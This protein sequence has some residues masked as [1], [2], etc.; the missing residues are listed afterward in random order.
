M[1]Y[2]LDAADDYLFDKAYSALLPASRFV[3]SLLQSANHTVASVPTSP[4]VSQLLSY[5]P[6]PPLTSST[7]AELASASIWPRDYILRQTLSLS[8]MTM[9]GIHL[10]YLTVAAASYYFIFNREMENHPRFLDGQVGKEIRCSLKAFPALTAMT[11]PWFVGEVRGHGRYYDRIDDYGWGYALASIPMFLLFTDYCI[12]WVHRLEHHPSIYKHLHKLHHKWIIPTPFAS[13]A[14]HPV[15]GYLQ[16]LPYHIFPMIFPLH[17]KLYLI[18]F[19]FVNLWSILIHDSD[20]ITGHPLE[21]II[22]GPAH[23]TLH[24]LYFTVNYGQYFTWADR[25]H[26]SYRQPD[27]SLD[28]MLQVKMQ[29][30]KESKKSQ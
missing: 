8:I 16:S 4:W 15:D 9:V 17:K 18:L 30:K 1:E 14:F 2:I 22:N 10:M 26:L 25:T 13:H 19:S 3:P 6:H 5:F 23:H 21:K 28:P 24:H 11:V 7:A 29:Q 20:M 12:Y 27:A